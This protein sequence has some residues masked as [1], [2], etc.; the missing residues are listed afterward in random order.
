MS[1]ETRE[2]LYGD[3]ATCDALDKGFASV[4]AFLRVFFALIRMAKRFM[5]RQNWVA[6]I[7]LL[8]PH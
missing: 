1:F 5:V 3:G 6:V 8:L 7:V 4:D 2:S